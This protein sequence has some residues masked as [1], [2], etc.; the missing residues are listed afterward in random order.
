M[1]MGSKW[2][3]VVITLERYPAANAANATYAT[4]STGITTC[5]SLTWEFAVYQ[6]QPFQ[7]MLQV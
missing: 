5:H 4:S 7:P 2:L 1:L 3:L 6:M